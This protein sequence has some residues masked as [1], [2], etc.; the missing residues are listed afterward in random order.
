[1]KSDSTE[2][3]PTD[4]AAVPGQW[5]GGDEF[6]EGA[7]EFTDEVSRR[8]FLTLAAASAALAGAAGCVR[9]APARKIVAQHAARRNHPGVRSTSHRRA[10]CGYGTGILVRSNE[11]R[12]TKIEGNPDHP[13][14]RAEPASIRS[15]RS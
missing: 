4:L 11:G 12:P 5:D 8:R 6:P 15:A 9:P 10:L 3:P 14:S 13:S 2:K 7:A 1:M